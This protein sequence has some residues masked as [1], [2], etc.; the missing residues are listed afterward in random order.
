MRARD[1]YAGFHESIAQTVRQSLAE[2]PLFAGMNQDELDIIAPYMH[3]FDVQ[4]GDV[5]FLE[6]ELGDYMCFVVQG[7]L[8][9]SKNGPRGGQKLL[10]VLKQGDSIGEMAVVDDFPR[11]ANVIAAQGTRLLT[12]SR[13]DFETLLRKEPDIGIRVLVALIRM[14]S[15]NLRKTS[16]KLADTL[17]PVI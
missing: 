16:G 12:L 10:A 15:G 11:S 4:E 9:V 1:P 14:L 7:S 13:R 6:G 17:L 3:F 2:I 8:D 5:V